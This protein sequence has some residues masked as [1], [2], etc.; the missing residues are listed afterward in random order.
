MKNEDSILSIL[1]AAFKKG[2]GL[3][4]E[5]SVLSSQIKVLAAEFSK[6]SQGYVSLVKLVASHNDSIET[7]I[8]NQE[9]IMKSIKSDLGSD[10][11]FPS[12]KKEKIEKPN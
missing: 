6:L 9:F 1:A 3:P 4:E 8:A 11:R 12:L 7:L 10:A 2:A 5:I